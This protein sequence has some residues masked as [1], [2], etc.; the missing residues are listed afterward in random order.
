MDDFPPSIAFFSFDVFVCRER[1]LRV[2]KRRWFWP[3]VRRKV[4]RGTK[5][6]SAQ[7]KIVKDFTAI[8]PYVGTTVLAYAFVVEAVDS[9]D[10]SRFMVSSDQGYSVWIADF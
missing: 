1:G 6:E 8:S 2:R 5:Y 10:L 9:R 7:S 4:L 3:V